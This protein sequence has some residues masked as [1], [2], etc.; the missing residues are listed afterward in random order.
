M[1][2][3]KHCFTHE[4]RTAGVKVRIGK[5][6]QCNFSSG[7]PVIEVPEQNSVENIFYGFH[8]L[9]HAVLHKNEKRDY[10]DLKQ[11][12]AIEQEADKFAWD[13]MRE[14]KLGWQKLGIGIL[15]NY[16]HGL[17]ALYLIQGGEMPPYSA[18]V[19]EE[20]FVILKKSGFEIFSHFTSMLPMHPAF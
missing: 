3:L 4:C 10:S 8:E 5:K 6:W 14:Y 16:T 17:I 12:I 11:R 18:H 7:K 1:K 19:D 2:G 15:N 13:M 20:N 9:G